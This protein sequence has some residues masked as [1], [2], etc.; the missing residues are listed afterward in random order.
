MNIFISS[1]FKV[2]VSDYALYSINSDLT[3]EDQVRID[4]FDL[5]I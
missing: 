2:K 4:L 3:L 5:G 1:K